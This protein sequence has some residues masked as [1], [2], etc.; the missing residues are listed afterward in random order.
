MI[1]L[2]VNFVLYISM[3]SFDVT[4][5]RNRGL[6]TIYLNLNRTTVE[7]FIDI[8]NNEAFFDDKYVI[9]LVGV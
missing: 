7:K 3:N 4:L 5:W 1:T 9:I 2:Q 8:S 6:H